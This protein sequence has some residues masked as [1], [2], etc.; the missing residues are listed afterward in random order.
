[1]RLLADDCAVMQDFIISNAM[2]SADLK[3]YNEAMHNV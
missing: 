2:V 3:S 1:M